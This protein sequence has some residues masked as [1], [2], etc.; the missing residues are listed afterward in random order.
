MDLYAY[1]KTLPTMQAKIRIFRRGG[2]FYA[3]TTFRIEMYFEAGAAEITIELSSET[4][5]ANYCLQHNIPVDDNR[6]GVEKYL[7]RQD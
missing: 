6:T 2:P 1:T 3:V 5:L 4:E 7:A